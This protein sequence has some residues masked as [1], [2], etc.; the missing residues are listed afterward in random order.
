MSQSSGNTRKHTQNLINIITNKNKPLS[1]QTQNT[2]DDSLK[3]L[4]RNVCVGNNYIFTHTY[5]LYIHIKVSAYRNMYNYITINKLL[6]YKA[7]CEIMPVLE[8]TLSM[9][10]SDLTGQ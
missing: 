4:L 7:R 8:L 9:S 6:E 3:V 2:T 10:L 5:I 1:N